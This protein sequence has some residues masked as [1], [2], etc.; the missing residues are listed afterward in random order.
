MRNN[1]EYKKNIVIKLVK[2]K[3]KIHFTLLSTP[4]SISTK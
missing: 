4:D 2:H 3:I 1:F